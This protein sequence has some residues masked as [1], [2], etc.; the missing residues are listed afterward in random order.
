VNENERTT[1]FFLTFVLCRALFKK[2]HPT[3]RTCVLCGLLTNYVI[4]G[5]STVKGAQKIQFQTVGRESKA[6]PPSATNENFKK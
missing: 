5:F 3:S 6:Y 2:P 4:F 1:T